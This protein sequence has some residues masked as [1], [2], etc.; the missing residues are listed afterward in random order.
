[1]TFNR[2]DL[3]MAGVRWPIWYDL[4]AEPGD[5]PFRFLPINRPAP[6]T[7]LPMYALLEPRRLY[8]HQKRLLDAGL[9]DAALQAE[10]LANRFKDYQIPLVPLVSEDLRLVTDSFVRVNS[11]GKRMNESH[12][13]RALAYA[14][15]CNVEGKIAALRAFR[16]SRTAR[17]ALCGPARRHCGARSPAEWRWTRSESVR[18][19]EPL[20]LGHDLR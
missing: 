10:S 12:M 18:D 6:P 2:E 4:A 9:D 16:R 7:W 14:D 1:M 17:A 13:V 8:E 11:G 3:H 15:D 20:V 19:R 5:R